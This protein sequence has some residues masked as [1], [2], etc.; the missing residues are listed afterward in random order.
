MEK[1]L[2]RLAVEGNSCA[3]IRLNSTETNKVADDISSL[4]SPID[5]NWAT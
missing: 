1:V 5:S 2:F 3:R 4:L